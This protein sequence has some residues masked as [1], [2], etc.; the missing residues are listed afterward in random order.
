MDKTPDSED[1]WIG[2]YERGAPDDKYIA[3]HWIYTGG[4]GIISNWEAAGKV[5]TNHTDVFELRMF[6][7]SHCCLRAKTNNLIGLV[8]CTAVIPYSGKSLK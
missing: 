7:R 1:Y 8:L 4:Q 2:I 6:N 5:A 3:H